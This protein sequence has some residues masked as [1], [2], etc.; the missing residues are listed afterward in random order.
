MK[1]RVMSKSTVVMYLAG[2]A[3]SLGAYYTLCR[4]PMVPSHPPRV[5][6]LAMSAVSLWVALSV[7]VTQSHD[8]APR[9]SRTN[10]TVVLDRRSTGTTVF[11]RFHHCVFTIPSRFHDSVS[12]SPYRRSSTGVAVRVHS[13]AHKA[14]RRMPS[15]VPSSNSH[16]LTLR[17]S[18]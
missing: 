8:L 16:V 1:E 5:Q 17:T 13:Q 6:F 7:Q 9:A 2:F 14:T 11:S 15:S 3:V 4:S 10:D 18:L 12:P